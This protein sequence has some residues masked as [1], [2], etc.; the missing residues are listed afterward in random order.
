MLVVVVKSRERKAERGGGGEGREK[1]YIKSI[2]E[3]DIYQTG[4]ES[5]LAMSMILQPPVTG[6]LRSS[7]SLVRTQA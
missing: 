7:G 1:L 3:Y 5:C 6:L 4:L 2:N